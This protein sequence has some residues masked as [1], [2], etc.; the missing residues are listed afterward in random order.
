M[1]FW[2]WV[3]VVTTTL[4]ALF[5]SETAEP[6]D[7]SPDGI[8]DT[9]KMLWRIIKLPSVLQYCGLLLTAKVGKLICICQL[10]EWKSILQ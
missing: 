2:A 4:T 7:E 5:K 6:E 10:N 8:I 1:Y 9:Y 3:F